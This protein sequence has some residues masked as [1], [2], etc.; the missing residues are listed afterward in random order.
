MHEDGHVVLRGIVQRTD[1]PPLFATSTLCFH[2]N[3]PRHRSLVLIWRSCSRKRSR[4]LHVLHERRIGHD[5][6]KA[7]AEGLILEP[8][9]TYARLVQQRQGQRTHTA[10]IVRWQP[11][12]ISSMSHFSG[13]RSS[14]PAY[15]LELPTGTAELQPHPSYC[16]SLAQPTVGDIGN[17]YMVSMRYHSTTTTVTSSRCSSGYAAPR[18]LHA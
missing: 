4:L 16:S 5:G 11:L 10:D 6:L 12:P 15:V 14:A 7:E 13:V 17:T 1:R 3:E 2:H 18:L 8:Q 9:Q